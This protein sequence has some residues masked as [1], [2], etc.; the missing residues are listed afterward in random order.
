MNTIPQELVSETYPDGLLIY[1]DKDH[2]LLIKAT[3]NH[4][5][6]ESVLGKVT[7][8]DQKQD[9]ATPGVFT[10]PFTKTPEQ[11]LC[12]IGDN[13]PHALSYKSWDCIFEQ[14]NKY[15]ASKGYR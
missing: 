11:Y 5:P 8:T 3:M 6:V 13:Q 1:I 12:V 10:F 15:L 4:R 7:V 2:N 9:I 14:L